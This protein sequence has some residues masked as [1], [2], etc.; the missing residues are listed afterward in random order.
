MTLQGGTNAERYASITRAKGPETGR[1]AP[2]KYG[3]WLRVIR[4]DPELRRSRGENKG[5]ALWTGHPEREEIRFDLCVGDVMVESPDGPTTEKM[6]EIAG[7]LGAKV[8]DDSSE[9]R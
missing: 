1:R 4:R 6:W 8:R 9:N 2:I 5:L 7:A 3:E